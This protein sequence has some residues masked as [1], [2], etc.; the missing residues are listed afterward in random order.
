[1]VSR[2]SVE[3]K[4]HFMAFITP[5]L[6][7]LKALLGS[8]GVDLPHV[9]NLI[10]DSELELHITRKSISRLHKTFRGRL[11]LCS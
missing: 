7:W 8:L 1:M 6:K 11:P 3:V 5:E 10:C 4:Y 2:S 9:I